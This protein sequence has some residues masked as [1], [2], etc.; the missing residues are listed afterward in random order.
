MSLGVGGVGAGHEANQ[1]VGESAD[2]ELMSVFGVKRK[3]AEEQLM[4][5]IPISRHVPQLSRFRHLLH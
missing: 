4:Q 5:I 2:D 3:I 1:K